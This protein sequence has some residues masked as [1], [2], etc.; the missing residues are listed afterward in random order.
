M[1]TKG[2][3]VINGE[4][5]VSANPDIIFVG[6]YYRNPV[7]NDALTGEY[8]SV[9]D[10]VKNGKVYMVPTSVTDWSVGSCELGLTTLWCAKLVA[11]E[12]FSDINMTEEVISFYKD[13]AGIEVSEE[14]ANSILSSGKRTE[15]GAFLGVKCSIPAN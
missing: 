3:V 4:E 11:P 6:G 7:Y 12:L 14:L 10:A 5:L 13:I 8:R 2:G 9:L 15:R 1:E